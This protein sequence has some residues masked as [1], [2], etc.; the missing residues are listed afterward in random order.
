M[1][2]MQ[3]GDATAEFPK[4]ESLEALFT[5]LEAPLLACAQRLLVL[6]RYCP[7]LAGLG[8]ARPLVDPQNAPG[9]IVKWGPPGCRHFPPTKT[10][11]PLA[12]E[13]G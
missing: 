7:V 8:R 12:R 5:A 10:P 1:G 9:R 13:G 3:P 6:G 2:A 11:S 4:W